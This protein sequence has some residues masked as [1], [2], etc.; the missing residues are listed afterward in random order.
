LSKE[1]EEDNV[2]SLSS[3]GWANEIRVSWGNF[4][5][6]ACTCTATRAV[7]PAVSNGP[8][9]FRN[10]V[11]DDHPA[12][13]ERFLPANISVTLFYDGT[14]LARRA[15]TFPDTRPQRF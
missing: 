8:K 2:V 9:V 12:R 6:I 10:Q 1:V 4:S 13:A 3:A 14:E 7:K 15:G 11:R 5:I